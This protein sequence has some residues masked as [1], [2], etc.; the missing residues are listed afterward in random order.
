MELA[1]GLV[2]LTALY[3]TVHFFI[4]QRKGWENLTT[5]EKV[6]SIVAMV[7]IGLLYLGTMYE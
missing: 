3:S 6:V 5:Y 2:G 1:Y 7:C 4:I